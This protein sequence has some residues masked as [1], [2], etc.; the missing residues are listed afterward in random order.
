MADDKAGLMS[1]D[2]CCFMSGAFSDLTIVLRPVLRRI[3]CRVM[4]VTSG[5]I[6]SLYRMIY[7]VYIG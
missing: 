3:Q 4:S 7:P 5:D 2:L 1:G 6:S